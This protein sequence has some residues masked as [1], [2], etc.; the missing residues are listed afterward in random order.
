MSN[1]LDRTGSILAIDDDVNILK[2][3]KL[4]LED[5]GY[6]VLL[7]TDGIYGMQLVKEHHPDLILLEMTMPGP[8]GYQVIQSIREYCSSPIIMIT[9]LHSE[10]ATLKCLALGA[11]DY[12]VKP[13]NPIEVVARIRAKLRRENS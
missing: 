12:V 13:F 5:E 9:A 1:D 6:S 4:T 11:D 3:L 7:A 8:T 2:V 10:E